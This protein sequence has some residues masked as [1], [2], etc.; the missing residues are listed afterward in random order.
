M[1]RHVEEL[2]N[3]LAKSL[4]F[5]LTQPSYPPTPKRNELSYLLPVIFPGLAGGG[6]VHFGDVN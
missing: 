3:D 6:Q 1:Y 2:W 5:Y 4:S